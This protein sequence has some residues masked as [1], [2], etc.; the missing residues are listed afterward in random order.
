MS[1]GLV[2]GKFAP[3]HRGHQQLIEHSLLETDHTIVLIYD[4]PG[5]ETPSLPVRASWIR[6][7]YPQVE[8]LEAW[9]GPREVGLDPATTRQHDDYLQRRLGHRAITHFFSSEPYGE[10]VSRGLACIDRRVDPE[11]SLIPI[12]ATEIRRDPYRH[13]AFVSPRVYRDLVKK[14]VFLGAPS[15]GKT[16]LAQELA[17]RF[18]TLWMPEYGR[19]YWE[20]HQS[21]RRLTVDQLLEIA[22]EHRR[23]EDQ[24][25]LESN[26]YLL[27]DTDATT[28]L[29]FSYYYHGTAHHELIELAA[30]TRDRYDLFFLCAPDIPYDDTWDRSGDANR[31]EMH[32]RVLSDLLTRKTPFHH[33]TGSLDERCQQVE[34]V[35]RDHATLS[36]L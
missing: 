26:R 27:V 20:Q 1:T 31:S 19:E 32:R 11:R 23:R 25:V 2:L 6:D 7:L 22:V 4:C 12:S 5:L 17:R 18:Q 35:I 29:Q 28:T 15:T 24:L 14:I 36:G 10:H 21:D 13:R 9:D 8:I 16:T 3:L 33:L 34:R 30:Q